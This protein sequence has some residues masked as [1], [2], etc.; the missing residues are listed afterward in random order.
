MNSWPSSCTRPRWNGSAPPANFPLTL[1]WQEGY[2]HSYHFIATFHRRTSRLPYPGPARCSLKP[3]GLVATQSPADHCSGG[4]HDRSL[5]PPHSMVPFALNIC[6]K[7]TAMNSRHPSYCAPAGR[8]HAAPNLTSVRCGL[9]AGGLIAKPTR[10][11]TYFE[12]PGMKSD[13]LK[14]LLSLLRG[15]LNQARR[16]KKPLAVG[17]RRAGHRHYRYQLL[18]A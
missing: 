8:E 12:N 7:A 14:P 15:E 6:G 9:T 3:V 16:R 1:R 2:D 18:P 13:L 5:A 11:I 17:D 10:W 4:S